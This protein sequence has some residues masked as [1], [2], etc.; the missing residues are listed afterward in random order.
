MKYKFHASPSFIN[1]CQKKC[2]VQIFWKSINLSFVNTTRYCNL[3]LCQFDTTSRTSS[4]LE[5]LL[6]SMRDYSILHMQISLRPQ[7][8]CRLHFLDGWMILL[9][10]FNVVGKMGSDAIWQKLDKFLDS[11]WCTNWCTEKEAHF[12]PHINFK[13]V[14]VK[15]E[16]V[17]LRAFDFI[18]RFNKNCLFLRNCI[19]MA[20]KI[21]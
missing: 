1:H 17:R 15:R 9:Y 19:Y 18:L 5:W 21:D 13:Y 2:F 4:L 16:L 3:K 14:S 6:F 12:F 7:F 10:P 11:V 8:L 20:H